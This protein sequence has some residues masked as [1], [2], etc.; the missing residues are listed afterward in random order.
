MNIDWKG[1]TQAALE[2][3]RET[4]SLRAMTDWEQQLEI[5]IWAVYHALAAQG[6]LQEH[7]GELLERLSRIENAAYMIGHA[8]GQKDALPW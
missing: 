2:R 1:A 7:S 5:D 3:I 6:P 8:Q 4:Q